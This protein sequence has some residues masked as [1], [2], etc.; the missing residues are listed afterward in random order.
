MACALAAEYDVWGR[1]GGQSDYVTAYLR[2]SDVETLRAVGY[3]VEIDEEQTSL[4][5]LDGPF[6]G[7]SFDFENGVVPRRPFRAFP[8]IAPSKRPTPAWPNLP[9]II[10]RWPHGPIFGDSYDSMTAVVPPVM[11]STVLKLTNSAIPG[12]KPKPMII[13]AIHARE[14]TTAEL[15]TG[16]LPNI[17]SATMVLTPTPPGFWTTPKSTFCP[18]SIQMDAKLPKPAICGAKTATRPMVAAPLMAWT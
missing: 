14:Y 13:A 10:P 6:L 11:T 5:G 18:T 4:L 7:H 17:L 16:A 12:P 3:G 1:S 2:P 9:Q 15:A 8:A